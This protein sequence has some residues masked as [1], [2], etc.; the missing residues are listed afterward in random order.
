[1][2]TEDNLKFYL[3]DGVLYCDKVEEPHRYFLGSL[4]ITALIKTRIVKP[5]EDKQ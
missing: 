4:E 2:T 3:E 1:M 5:A